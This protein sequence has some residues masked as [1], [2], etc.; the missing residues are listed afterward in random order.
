MKLN[1]GCGTRVLTGYVNI[2]KYIT[3]PGITA[4]DV[5]ALEFSDGSVDE[6]L[7]EDILEHFP[8]LE[9]RAVLTEWIRVLKSGGI[10]TVQFPDMMT[11]CKLLIESN[12]E[13]EWEQWNRKIFG[14]QGDGGPGEGM[15]HY[16][17]FSYAFLRCHCESVGLEYV[18]HKPLNTNCVLTMRKR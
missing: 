14:G 11:L 16:T 6:V 9:W 15:Y 3:G 5:R 12:D 17:G 13:N 18:A 10:L 1:V 7:A 2:D 8:R 4:G